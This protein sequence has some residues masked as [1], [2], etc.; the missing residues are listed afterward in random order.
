[1]SKR[2]VLMAMY[3]GYVLIFLCCN[4]LFFIISEIDPALLLNESCNRYKFLW[5]FTV[6]IPMLCIFKLMKR[7]YKSEYQYPMYSS[8]LGHYK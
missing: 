7:F 4:H 2:S 1:M 3:V 8:I 5:F 6:F